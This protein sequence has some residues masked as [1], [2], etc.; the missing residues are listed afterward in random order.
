MSDAAF[1]P[2]VPPLT[3]GLVTGGGVVVTLLLVSLPTA[4]L[5]AAVGTVAWTVAV[6]RHRPR[7]L[8]GGAGSVALAL[9]FAA[10]GGVSVPVLVLASGAAFVTYDLAAT[11]L[12]LATQVGS[13]AETR[14]LELARLGVTAVGAALVAGVGYVGFSLASG[15]IPPAAIALIFG[16]ILLAELA[17][18]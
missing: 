17:L 9:L 6:R 16:G 1:E 10:I 15:S 13:R 14:E 5:L 4:A 18:R 7:Y 8:D 2:A 3:Q 11:G 12:S